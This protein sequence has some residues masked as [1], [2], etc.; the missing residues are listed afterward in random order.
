MRT[1]RS[2]S[3]CP[4]ANAVRDLCVSVFASSTFFLDIGPRAFNAVP[5]LI[6]IAV[7]ANEGDDIAPDALVTHKILMSVSLFYL[8]S[9]AFMIP[10]GKKLT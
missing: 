8:Q 1:F 9:M 2:I 4:I 10:E 7:R 3:G 5:R 6:A